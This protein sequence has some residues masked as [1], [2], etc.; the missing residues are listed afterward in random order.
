[1]HIQPRPLLCFPIKSLSPRITKMRTSQSNIK[2]W[3][4]GLHQ[5]IHIAA[6]IHIMNSKHL[7]RYGL[8]I[9]SPPPEPQLRR[10]CERK[11][12]AKS[13][14]SN[15]I[16]QAH[17]EQHGSQ[18]SLRYMHTLKIAQLSWEDSM[19]QQK[20]HQDTWLIRPGYQ[21]ILICTRAK[22]DRMSRLR[23][24]LLY[25]WTRKTLGWGT[26]LG[27]YNHRIVCDLSQLTWGRAPRFRIL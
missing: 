26:I 21:S 24:E 18:V 7:T 2:F 25:K 17:V 27:S 19:S 12:R 1:M 15:S 10:L 11:L 8:P 13:P 9:Q 14:A 20:E 6:F 22:H 4:R 23:G 5:I 16:L 3:K